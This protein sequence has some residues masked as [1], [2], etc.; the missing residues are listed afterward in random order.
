MDVNALG[1]A[2]DGAVAKRNKYMYT[3]S[4]VSYDDLRSEYR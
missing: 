4:T 3:Y 1:T 2:A